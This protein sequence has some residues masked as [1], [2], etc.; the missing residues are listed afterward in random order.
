MTRKSPCKR[1]EA[2]SKSNRMIFDRFLNEKR[3][4]FCK[5]DNSFSCSEMSVFV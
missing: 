3:H 4:L 2:W 1:I 5:M